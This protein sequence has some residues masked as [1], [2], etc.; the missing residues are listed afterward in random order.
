MLVTL[1]KGLK[2]L[3]LLPYPASRYV[4]DVTLAAPWAVLYSET[5][6]IPPVARILPRYS[7]KASHFTRSM[8]MIPFHHA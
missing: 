7:L 8:N 4:L 3:G 5:R 1:F 2:G 6:P